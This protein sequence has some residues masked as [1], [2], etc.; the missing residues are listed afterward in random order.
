M[1]R[2]IFSVLFALFY[3]LCF[4]LV[5]A[6]PVQAAARAATVSGNWSSTATWG[7]VA[8]PTSADTVTINNGV[9]V[10]VDGAAACASLTVNAQ[11]NE[12]GPTRSAW[13]ALSP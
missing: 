2:N 5:G 10:T 4:S 11:V 9:T 3:L 12:A 13:A 6:I 7:G 1:K 8:V